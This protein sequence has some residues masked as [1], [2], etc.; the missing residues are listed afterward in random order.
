MNKIASFII[1]VNF[2]CCYHPLKIVIIKYIVTKDHY[3]F[4]KNK[5]ELSVVIWI[6]F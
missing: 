6:F 1:L 2:F 4:I 5:F 3:M